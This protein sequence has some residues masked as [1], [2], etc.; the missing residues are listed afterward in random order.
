MVEL[1]FYLLPKITLTRDDATR[2]LLLAFRF[3][4]PQFAWAGLVHKAP[5]Y[6]TTFYKLDLENWRRVLSLHAALRLSWRRA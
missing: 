2:I 3:L 4:G 5:V 6:G 1:Q